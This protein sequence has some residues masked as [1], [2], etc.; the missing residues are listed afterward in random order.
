MIAFV[1]TMPLA[2]R[3]EETRPGLNASASSDS[4]SKL[5]SRARDLAM[6][7]ARGD[8]T[9]FAE[10]YDRYQE[11]LFRLTL[12]L[13]HGDE[14]LACEIVQSTFLTAAAKLREVQSEEHLWNWLARAARQH[15]SKAWRRQ[16]RDAAFVSVAE[17]PDQIDLQPP[18]HELEERLDSALS[19][20]DEPERRLLEW[21]YFDRLSLREIATRMAL[22]PKA[23]SNRLDRARTKLRQQLTRKKGDDDT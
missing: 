7:V 16:K 15:L 21:F 20:M 13:G 18:D 4:A 17:P 2:I 1:K 23:V 5:D 12:A 3:A 9:A 14:A 22:T 10:L 11:R 8:E 19:A 6:A